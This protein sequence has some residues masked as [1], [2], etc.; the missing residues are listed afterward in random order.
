[1]GLVSSQQL[2]ELS[3]KEKDDTKPWLIAMDE[4]L[5]LLAQQAAA[6]SRRSMATQAYEGS[7]QSPQAELPSRD[8]KAQSAQ[9]PGPE[10]ITQ[11][12]TQHIVLE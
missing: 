10:R 8:D 11:A 5:A 2:N 7:D 9:P 6:M 12:G 1:M 3:A 4:D